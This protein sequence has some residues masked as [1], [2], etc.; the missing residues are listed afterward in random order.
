MLRHPHVD[1]TT[2]NAKYVLST[3]PDAVPRILGP[4]RYV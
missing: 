3:L 2:G 4:A 1:A